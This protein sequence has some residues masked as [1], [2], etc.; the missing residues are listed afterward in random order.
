[1][2]FDYKYL[3]AA[4]INNTQAARNDTPP[5]GVMAPRMLIFVRVKAYRLP[6]NRMIPIS[7]SQPDQFSSEVAGSF[8][9]RTPIIKI[10]VAWNIWYVT[11]VFQVS[12]YFGSTLPSS[13]C[14]PKA[15]SATARKALIAPIM[16]NNFIISTSIFKLRLFSQT[17]LPLITK[18][19]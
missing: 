11:P 2:L 15:P 9:S 14:A 16:I 12:R 1:M 4:M 5:S 18:W 8:P 6:E 3:T 10:P 7:I 17:M 19:D 13:P